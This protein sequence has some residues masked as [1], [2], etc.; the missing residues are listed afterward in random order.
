MAET[1]FQQ[2]VDEICARDP[3][4]ASEAYFFLREA[5]DYTVKAVSKAAHPPGRLRHV[6]GQELCEGIREYAL[7]EFGPLAA[8]VLET[9]G[10]GATDDFGEMVYNLID[11]GKLG[12][13]ETDRKSDF[14]G[15]YDFA[16]AFVSPYEVEEESAHP[17]K[18][19]GR[20][21]E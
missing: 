3:R 6:T 15:V 16:E 10:L 18:R 8:L 12:K 19:R 21:G 4:Y 2:A 17:R 1:S 20:R 5:L 14:A 13:T 11:A 9:W 7:R